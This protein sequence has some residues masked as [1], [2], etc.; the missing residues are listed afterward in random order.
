M[1][2]MVV[3]CFCFMEQCAVM[4]AVW[5]AGGVVREWHGV[6]GKE[7]NPMRKTGRGLMERLLLPV[8]AVAVV[9]GPGCAGE[10]V[11]G[12]DG[13]ITTTPAVEATSG[14]KEETD[15]S[16]QVTEPV[17]STEEP[18][19]VT[20]PVLPTETPA[21]DDEKTTGEER[22]LPE[23]ELTVENELY[24]E[25][26]YEYETLTVRSENPDIVQA[27]LMEG[28]Y[29]YEENR[30]TTGAMLYG[31]ANGT[32]E[33][34]VADTT[35]GQEA[36]W[37]VTVE[38]PAD[39]SG[40]QKLIDW[41]LANGESNDIG[42]KELAEGT[43]EDGGRAIVEYATMDENINFYFKEKQGDL[44]IEWNLIP[45]PEETT[46][47]YITMRIGE[48]F[49]TATVDLATYAG[50]EL[51]FEKGWFKVPVE[52]KMQ[53]SANEVSKRA[54]EAVRSLLEKKTGMTMGEVVR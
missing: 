35:S 15:V 39:E 48:D 37:K 19:Q 53:Q 52:E 40:K 18:V 33:L 25:F 5:F 26:A 7:W 29:D 24:F 46:E 28:E 4:W 9:A 45:T 6:S 22:T 23:Y 44:K 14:A 8:L 41:L 13:V 31:I 54:Y 43:V 27:K 2:G 20:E 32:T 50:E 30:E 34:V 36:R 49:V 42:D 38:K 17:A 47:Y 21:A 1:R 12:K 10:K 3:S 11:T 16:E 51:A